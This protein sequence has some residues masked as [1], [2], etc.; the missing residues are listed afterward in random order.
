MLRRANARLELA[1]RGSN[2]G[3]WENVM[4]DGDFQAGRIHCSNIME[5]LDYP[6][7]E[8]SIDFA[9]MVGPLHAEDRGRLEQAIQAYFA[10]Q[11]E[12]F[13]LEYRGQHRDGSYR[14]F[15]SRGIAVRDAGGKPIRFAGT[16]VDITDLKQTEGAL[17]LA[18]A[19]LDL[20]MRGSNIVIV[21]LSMPDGVLE[22]GRWD[23]VSA[24]DRISGHDRTDLATDFAATMPRVHPDDQ[25]RVLGALRAHL[26]GQTREFEAEGRIRHKDGSYIWRLGAAW[27]C[28]T[29]REERFAS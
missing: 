15:V 22:N 4:P 13:R 3:V 9:T 10:G 29:Q 19:R 26:S 20:A 18:N 17:R 7:P 12:E 8:S 27:P 1:L 2:I 11:T 6:A 25:E 23:W 21:E 24:G 5:Q 14:W 28:A 16:R